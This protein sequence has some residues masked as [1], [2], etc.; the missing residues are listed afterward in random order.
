MVE[1]APHK[2]F[3]FIKHNS[4]FFKAAGTSFDT[5]L[6]KERKSTS[7]NIQTDLVG[8]FNTPKCNFNAALGGLTNDSNKRIASEIT[9]PK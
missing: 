5:L 2:W 9:I 7:Q 8:T 6:K 1:K 4:Y 3:S